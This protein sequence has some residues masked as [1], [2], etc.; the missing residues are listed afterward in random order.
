M[1]QVRQKLT[2]SEDAVKLTSGERGDLERRLLDSK[3]SIEKLEKSKSELMQLIKLKE[4]NKAEQDRKI[5]DLEAKVVELEAKE[6]ALKRELRDVREML[7]ES[8]E[9]GRFFEAKAEEMQRKL[10]GLGARHKELEMEREAIRVR[11]F[12]LNFYRHV[13]ISSHTIRIEALRKKS[14]EMWLDEKLSDYECEFP[15]SKTPRLPWNEMS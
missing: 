6:N 7:N 10:K 1:Q 5:E 2:S 9:T 11:Q 15:S 8:E 3:S 4:E 12:A 14:L 13:S